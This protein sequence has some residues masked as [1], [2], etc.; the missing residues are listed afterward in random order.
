M[1][2]G[3]P[4]L[5]DLK[6]RTLSKNHG[7][8]LFPPAPQGQ[9][10]I[11]FATASVLLFKAA[12]ATDA[13]TFVGSFETGI[14][15]ALFC[16]LFMLFLTQASFYIFSR[17][18]SFAKAYSYEDVW[19]TVISSRGTWVPKLFL[20]LAYIT[21][22][23]Y[24][25]WEIVDYVPD[26]LLHIWPD[27]PEILLSPWFLQY[28]FLLPLALPSLVWKRIGQ[29]RWGG[30]LGLFAYAIALISMVVHLFRTQWDGGYVS[31]SDVVLAKLD[32]DANLQMLTDYNAAFFAHSFI[33]I[34]A[35]EM[36]RPT[37]E[38]TMRM[39]WVSFGITAFFSYSVPLVG[40]LY[41]SDC[42]EYDNV[43]NALDSDNPEV[44]VAKIA[45][46]VISLLSTVLYGYHMAGIATGMMIP[47]TG[48][49]GV[50]GFCA[51]VA[52]GFVA[53]SFNSIE[54][55]WANL[56]YDLGSCAFTVL[57]FVLPP[58]YYLWHFQFQVVKWGIVAGIVLV[59]G[60]MMLFLS[61]IWIITGLL[62]ES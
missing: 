3:N 2:G 28:V 11:S 48:A 37:N 1:H 59:L 55:V 22:T 8:S 12:C 32:F 5:I 16:C 20:L 42:E 52:L 51:N 56:I 34:I 29:F 33:A 23:Y 54:D 41:F 35:Q 10:T 27:C 39:T 9:T 62:E 26:I 43:L 47:G 31:A 60:L 30:W 24:G 25:F 4:S 49:Y 6:V 13:F 7:D 18:W 15:V 45:V 36:D 14:F 40:Y 17:T 38:R 44:L 53:I 46:L 19:R 50:P 58:V 57:G 21:C 61:I